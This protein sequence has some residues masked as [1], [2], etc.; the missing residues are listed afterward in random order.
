MV[1]VEGREKKTSNDND[2]CRL[3]YA[4]FFLIMG[5]NRNQPLKREY[6]STLKELF[7]VWGPMIIGKSPIG[8]I[9]QKAVRP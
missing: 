9:N 6:V 5:I 8:N 7:R 1:G 3:H 4:H 2:L